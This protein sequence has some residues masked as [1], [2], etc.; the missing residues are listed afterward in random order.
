M[1][2]LRIASFFVC[3]I[4]ML[5]ACSS[6]DKTATPPTTGAGT[7]TS[8]N[9]GATSAPT[10]S[11][12]PTTPG[13]KGILAFRAVQ[14]QFPWTAPP[15]TGSTAPGQTP[16][17]GCAKLVE[18]S[19]KQHSEQQAVLPARDHASCYTVGPVLLTGASIDLASVLHDSTSSQWAINVHFADDAFLDKI[20]KPL[21]GQQITIDLDSVVQSAPT[22]NPGITGNDVEITGSFTKQQAIDV[23]ARIAGIAPASVTIDPP[24]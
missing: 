13:P 3:G 5:G 2:R 23:V 11:T 7:S 9:T 18:D 21:V 10:P 6:S 16:F 15:S 20:A 8:S 12:K 4:V 19:R 1:I 14:A 22:I 17:P 24:E